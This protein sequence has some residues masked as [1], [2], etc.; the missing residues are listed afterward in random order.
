MDSNEYNALI[1]KDKDRLHIKWI[2]I[3]FEKDDRISYDG[4]YN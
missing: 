2:Y 3:G 1:P 4:G